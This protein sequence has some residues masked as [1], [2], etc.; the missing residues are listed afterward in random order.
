MMAQSLLANIYLRSMMQ[1][2]K[3]D[4]L[5]TIRRPFAGLGGSFPRLKN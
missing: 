2:S 1:W 3:V 4:S 5:V